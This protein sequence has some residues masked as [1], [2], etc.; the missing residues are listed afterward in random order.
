MADQDPALPTLPVAAP[1]QV[2]DHAAVLSE[3]DLERQR[4]KEAKEATMRERKRMLAQIDA[5]HGRGPSLAAQLAKARREREGE[6]R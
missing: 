3:A 5:D 1:A 2:G 6:G 4:R